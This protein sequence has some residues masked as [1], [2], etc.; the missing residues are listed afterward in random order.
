MSIFEE[1]TSLCGDFAV[2]QTAYLDAHGRAKDVLGAVKSRLEAEQTQTA[3]RMAEL[4]AQKQDP[5][6]SETVRRMAA[7]ELKQIKNRAASAPTPE[8]IEAFQ[9]EITTAD[10]AVRDMRVLKQKVREAIDAVNAEVAR[11][12][13]ETLGHDTDLRIRWLD[14]LKQEFDRLGGGPQ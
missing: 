1:F 3:A 5:G 11:L 12:R 14:R 8:E 4:E 2:C 9:Q 10:D 13:G 6:R 7:L